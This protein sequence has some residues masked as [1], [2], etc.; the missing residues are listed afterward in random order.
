MDA[1]FAK[2]CQAGV[3]LG[4]KRAAEAPRSPQRRWV[5]GG[6]TPG[7]EDQGHTIPT[8]VNQCSQCTKVQALELSPWLK[9]PRKNCFF[10]F[11]FFF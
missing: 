1:N 3:E 9:S 4:S 8:F 7:V 2:L 5:T 11:L 10:F 6:A